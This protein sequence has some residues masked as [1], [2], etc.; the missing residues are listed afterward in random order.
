M[1]DRK[2]KKKEDK[3]RK[4][5]IA[6]LGVVLLLGIVSRGYVVR[7]AEKYPAKPVTF[8]I[9]L[10]AGAGA[11]VIS[12]QYCENLG[13]FLGK[14]I[15]VVNKPGAGSSIG[16]REIHDAKP[17]GYTIG[18]GTISLITNKLQGLLP[19][20]YHDFTI[21]GVYATTAPIIV[22]ATKGKQIFKTLPE[23]IEFA[24]LNPGKVKMAAGSKGQ[25]WWIFAMDFISTAGL[26]FNVIP[27][28]GAG[29]TSMIQVG[30]GHVDIGVVTLTE[31]K[32]LIDAGNAQLL[33]IFGKNRPYAFPNTPTLEELGIKCKLLFSPTIAMGPPNM[34]KEITE[35]LVKAV[36]AANN[37]QEWRKKV[38]AG[39][40]LRCT[41]IPPHQAIEEFE[42]IREVA[43]E[44]MSK[45]GILKEK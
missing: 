10:E 14:P 26:S 7:A 13:A 3:M 20:D 18:L 32:P 39:G 31:A 17:D 24:K 45:A 35:V 25:A 43:S 11:D 33:T 22:A 5:F 28:E 40:S 2:G 27:Q 16:Y 38:E 42:K 23:V 4:I 19:Y 30:G 34:P 37:N 41:Y 29:M 9:P 1:P 8:I 15:L 12:R 21:L 36:E 6:C 44:M